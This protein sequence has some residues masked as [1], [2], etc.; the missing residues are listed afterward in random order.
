[1]TGAPYFDALAREPVRET[2]PERRVVFA[3]Q[4]IQGAITADR[5]EGSY[6]GALAVA[7]AVAPSEL[8]VLP[9]PVQPSGLIEGLV[10]RH[11][12]PAGVRQT[13]ARAGTLHAELPGAFVLVSGPSNAVFEAS[14]AGVPSIVVDPRDTDPGTFVADGL[15]I[16]VAD[17]AAAGAAAQSLLDPGFRAA[18][19]LRAREATTQYLGPPDGRAAE[20][21]AALI[22]E[23]AG[24][25]SRDQVRG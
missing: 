3:A 10:A 23:L 16:G 4:Y 21:T 11:D 22:L 15:A 18:V 1:V 13:L 24:P 14:L 5:F 25:L 12:A 7:E 2:L 17:G 20:R 6:L 19:L 9:H 8:I